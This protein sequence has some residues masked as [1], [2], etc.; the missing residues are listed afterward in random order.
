MHTITRSVPGLMTWYVDGRALENIHFYRDGAVVLSV[1]RGWIEGLS[2]PERHLDGLTLKN[3]V[4]RALKP[5]L[6]TGG[7]FYVPVAPK[8]PDR[9]RKAEAYIDLA[10]GDVVLGEPEEKL[11]Y[12][13]DTGD[14]Y[15][16]VRTISADF[17]GS[18]RTITFVV[19]GSQTTKLTPFGAA[20]AA[21]GEHVGVRAH[22]PSPETIAKNP[23]L[24]RLLFEAAAV[25]PQSSVVMTP[26]VRAALQILATALPTTPTKKA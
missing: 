24:L 21:V 25:A 13:Q 22:D 15:H 1:G 4:R 17:E 5:N 18:Q 9:D 26:A 8:H 12:Q 6:K 14:V 16:M 11:N 10:A 3:G 7:H 2:Y 20:M 19:P 23:V